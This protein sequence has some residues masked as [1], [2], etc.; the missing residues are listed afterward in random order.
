MVF[1]SAR[2]LTGNALNVRAGMHV[3]K[4]NYTLDPILMLAYVGEYDDTRGDTPWLCYEMHEVDITN[5][6]ILNQEIHVLFSNPLLAS[7]LQERYL[8][9]VHIYRPVR[10]LHLGRPGLC[11][12][13]G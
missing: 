5:W 1:L 13:G 9:L 7:L 6:G 8:R 11:T 2:N 3:S 4:N 10:E 12:Q